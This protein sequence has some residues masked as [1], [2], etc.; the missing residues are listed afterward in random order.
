MLK[1]EIGDYIT[2]L[3]P[4]PIGGHK[5]YSVDRV[6]EQYQGEKTKIISI[7]NENVAPAYRLEIDNGR[8]FWIDSMFEDDK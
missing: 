7:V 2:I 8:F 3:S 1:R 6:M 4:I 5:G